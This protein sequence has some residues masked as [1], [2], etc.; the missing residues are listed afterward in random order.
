MTGLLRDHN[1]A[2]WREGHDIWG[3]ALRH[4]SHCIRMTHAVLRIR[5]VVIM[6]LVAVHPLPEPREFRN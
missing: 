1:G 2:G 3:H 6:V 5:V 4:H